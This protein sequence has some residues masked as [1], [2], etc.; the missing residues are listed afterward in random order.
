VNP[1]AGLAL[2]NLGRHKG[3][4]ALTLFAIAA[5]VACLVLMGGYVA[6]IFERLREVTIHS[7]LGHLQIVTRS[8]GRDHRG[9]VAERL[10]PG[11]SALAADIARR[12]GVS[13]VL[14][15]A[16]FDA[17]LNNGRADFPVIVR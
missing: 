4:S 7:R 1:V 9:P 8:G 2:R 6:D 15:R 10:L 13:V 5:G 14:G 12:P 11:A 3:R 17:L 16:H